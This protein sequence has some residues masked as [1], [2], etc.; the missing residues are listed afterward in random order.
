MGGGTLATK[1]KKKED[2]TCT[3]MTRFGTGVSKV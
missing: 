2:E 3:I 1:I